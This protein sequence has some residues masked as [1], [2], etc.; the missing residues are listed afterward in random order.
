MR[1]RLIAV[2]AIVASVVTAVGIGWWSLA[3]S[4]NRSR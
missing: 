2:V 3:A 4:R 1:W